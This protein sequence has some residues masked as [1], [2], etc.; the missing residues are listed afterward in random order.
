MKVSPLQEAV[1]LLEK[2]QFMEIVR[3]LNP[4]YI[5]KN[6]LRDVYHYEGWQHHHPDIPD[7]GTP[8]KVYRRRYSKHLNIEYF[9]MQTGSLI[10]DT[11]GGFHYFYPDAKTEDERKRN[12]AILYNSEYEW[13]WVVLQI[14]D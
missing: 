8:V 7:T 6:E 9:K 11:D 2:K 10:R 5:K 3:E 13:S 4:D 14:L 1:S 12:K